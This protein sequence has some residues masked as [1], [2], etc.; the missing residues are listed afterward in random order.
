[1]KTSCAFATV[2]VDL[3][4]GGFWKFVLCPR[5][6]GFDE[7][8]C[9]SVTHHVPQ[10]AVLRGAGCGCSQMGQTEPAEISLQL[11]YKEHLVLVSGAELG[12][13]SHDLSKCSLSLYLSSAVL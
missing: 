13:P 4:V 7:P 2:S 11:G 6:L 9:C 5:P 1:M 12:C 3:K 8:Y 10:S